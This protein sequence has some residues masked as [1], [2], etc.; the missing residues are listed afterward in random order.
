MAGPT[1]PLSREQPTRV[2]QQKKAPVLPGLQLRVSCL[3][4]SDLSPNHN[5]RKASIATGI[6]RLCKLTVLPKPRILSFRL[7]T[8][9]DE[10]GFSYKQLKPRWS[11]LFLLAGR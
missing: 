1:C 8:T 10:V 6:T 3:R 4:P 11:G 9:R 2:R 7:G 5:G